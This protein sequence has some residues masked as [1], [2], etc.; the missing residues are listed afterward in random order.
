VPNQSLQPTAG[1]QENLHMTISTLKFGAQL[2][3]TSGG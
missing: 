1:R 2:G 3:S